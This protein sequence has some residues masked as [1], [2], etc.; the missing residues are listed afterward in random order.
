MTADFQLM[1]HTTKKLDCAVGKITRS[2]ARF[3]E[4][5][6]RLIAGRMWNKAF[7]HQG[8]T[9]EITTRQPLPGDAGDAG[10]PRSH[11]LSLTATR[12]RNR[13][14]IF[15]NRSANGLLDVST[16][17][18]YELIAGDTAYLLRLSG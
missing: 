7:S 6:T 13:R 16:V 4:V 17:E 15:S 1:I 3:I 2:I 9:V 10:S 12:S 14:A 11:S 5:R 8:R 18:L